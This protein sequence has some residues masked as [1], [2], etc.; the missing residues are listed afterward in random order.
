[1]QNTMCG[2][3]SVEQIRCIYGLGR[4]LGFDNDGLHEKCKAVT[5]KE[6]ISRL[7]KYQAMDLIDSMQGKKRSFRPAEYERPISR[8]SA[9]QIKVILGLAAK[10]GWLKDD[11]IDMDRVNG[12]IRNQYGVD[13]ID[14]IDPEDAR[15]C[16]EALKAMVAGGRTERKGYHG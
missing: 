13:H 11:K 15:K 5:G 10:L 8:A 14:W 7:T 9:G 12:F 1:M 16:I 6:H 4:K 3:A 2:K